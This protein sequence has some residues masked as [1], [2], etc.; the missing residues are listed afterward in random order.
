[1]ADTELLTYKEASEKH[2]IPLNTLLSWA[3]RR[4]IKKYKRGDGRIFVDSN[5][6]AEVWRKKQEVK[7]LD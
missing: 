5:E 7:P 1:M 4:E 2:G 6:V 3:M